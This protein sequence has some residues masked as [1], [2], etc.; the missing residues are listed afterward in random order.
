MRK[1][2]TLL[3]QQLRQQAAQESNPEKLKTIAAQLVRILKKAENRPSHP[4]V[5][6]LR[7]LRR[8]LGISLAHLGAKLGCS[9]MTVSRWERGLL[10]PSNRGYVELG[11]LAGPPQGWIFWNLAGITVEDVRTMLMSDE[12]LGQVHRNPAA[13]ADPKSVH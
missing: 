9:A 3:L 4:W 1:R 7:K 11:K 6:P 2:K 10:E 13:S 12:L 8:R 5:S